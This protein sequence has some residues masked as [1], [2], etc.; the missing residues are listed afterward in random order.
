MS[1]TQ[2]FIIGTGRSGTT[3]LRDVL[4]H[5]P[6]IY[7]YP[8]ELRFMT[9]ANGL[10]DMADNLTVNWNP[11]NASRSVKE[12][13]ELI[14]K[15][16]WNEPLYHRYISA[17]FDLI[18]KGAGRK[19]RYSN[20]GNIIPESHLHSTLQALIDEITIHRVPGYWLGTESYNPFP[21]LYVTRPYD[22]EELYP[23]LGQFVDDLL[24]YPLK[25]TS[26]EV[27]CDDTPI[28][29]MQAHRI[30]KMLGSARMIHLYRDPRDVVASYADSR[31][32]W[33]PNDPELSAIWVR[34]IIEHWF[35][36]RQLIPDHQ[37]LEVKYEEMVKNQRECMGKMLEF[38][39]CEYDPGVENID[40]T[41]DSIGRY[42]SEMSNREVEKV[43]KIVGPILDE[44]YK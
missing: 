22:E 14:S 20:L 2:L 17:F 4:G 28:N 24:S 37:Y 11:F 39:G 12:F 16:I 26:K 30:A 7:A 25:G 23:I 34:E 9:D 38:I 31:Q 21:K 44:Y 29:I 35:R 5:H 36:V 41:T 10:M 33:A 42:K 1:R 6:D 40:L 3:I 13:K 18:L 19:Y 8:S 15:Y 32:A 27:W 43:N